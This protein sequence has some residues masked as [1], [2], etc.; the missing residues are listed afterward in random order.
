M[1]V[2]NLNKLYFSQEIAEYYAKHGNTEERWKKPP[3]L[4]R[5]KV[6]DGKYS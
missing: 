2:V 5:L 3:V 1:S 4:E 6:W